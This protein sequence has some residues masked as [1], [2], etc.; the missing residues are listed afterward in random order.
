ML[1]RDR[2]ELYWATRVTF[3]NINL[4][5]YVVILHSFRVQR[6]QAVILI[7]IFGVNENTC[8]CAILSFSVIVDLYFTVVKSDLDL[9]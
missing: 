1:F 5:K 6:V 2:F 3:G 9:A 7:L 4:T 8:V